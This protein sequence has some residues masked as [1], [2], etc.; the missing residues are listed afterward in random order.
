MCNCTLFCDKS[1]LGFTSGKMCDIFDR[2]DI[3]GRL[4]C[5]SPLIL[6]PP[7]FGRY[8]L[9]SVPFSVS[10]FVH[11]FWCN[12]PKSAID[13]LVTLC[14]L[15]LMLTIPVWLLTWLILF[16]LYIFILY[17]SSVPT[18]EFL[19]WYLV[20]PLIFLQYADS[21]VL[22]SFLFV[23][24]ILGWLAYTQVQKYATRVCIV[25]YQD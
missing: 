18:S 11:L 9:I 14:W 1:D 12:T 17:F 23:H 24:Y 20:L 5:I 13:V 10:I 21:S 25:L 6:F 16:N 7:T 3:P 8:G 2:S 22:P 4:I 19:E 15:L